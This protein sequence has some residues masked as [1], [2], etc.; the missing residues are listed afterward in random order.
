MLSSMLKVHLQISAFQLHKQ[1]SKD[2]SLDSMNEMVFDQS[3]K[4]CNMRGC[5]ST[6]EQ[7]TNKY[8]DIIFSSTYG[9]SV[10]VCRFK[11]SRPS[12]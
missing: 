10:G 11:T 12:F 9:S 7:H 4:L 1:N 2:L 6:S 3:G 5:L 8:Y